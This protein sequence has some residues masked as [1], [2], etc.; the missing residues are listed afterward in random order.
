VLSPDNKKDYRY[1]DIAKALKSL[2]PGHIKLSVV[3]YFATW[4]D[5]KN[6]YAD[7]ATVKAMADWQTV[8]S[9]IPPQ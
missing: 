2:V 6:N 1:D 7:W 3:K 9:Y 5:V 4:G 8:K